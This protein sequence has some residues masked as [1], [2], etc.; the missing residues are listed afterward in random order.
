MA[1]SEEE[2]DVLVQRVVKDITNAFKKNPNIGV[3]LTRGDPEPPAAV[4]QP[5]GCVGSDYNLESQRS[6]ES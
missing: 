2:V 4:E 1:E 5:S 3:R 6:R